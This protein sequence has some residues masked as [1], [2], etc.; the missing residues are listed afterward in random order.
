MLHPAW[1][2][3]CILTAPVVIWACVTFF[4]VLILPLNPSGAGEHGQRDVF[5]APRSWRLRHL[6]QPPVRPRPLLH[7]R[8]QLLRGDKRRNVSRHPERHVVSATG[9]TAAYCVELL[10]QYV[11]RDEPIRPRVGRIALI[12]S[13]PHFVDVVLGFGCFSVHVALH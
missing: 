11:Q 8:L 6:L 12:V 5:W 1:T 9:T 13:K 2:N 3:R 10:P 4:L 7:H